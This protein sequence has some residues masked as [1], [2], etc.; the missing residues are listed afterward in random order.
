MSQIDAFRAQPEQLSLD[1]KKK[2]YRLFVDN[3]QQEV[4]K[5]MDFAAQHALNLSAA[6]VAELITEIDQ[7]N[8]SRDVSWEEAMPH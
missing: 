1:E 3:P 7:D 2:L 8:R 5:I 4:L 6:D